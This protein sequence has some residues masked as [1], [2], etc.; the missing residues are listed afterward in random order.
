[1]SLFDRMW[2][3]PKVMWLHRKAVASGNYWNMSNSATTMDGPNAI[4][5]IRTNVIDETHI[6]PGITTVNNTLEQDGLRRSDTTNITAFNPYDRTRIFEFNGKAEILSHYAKYYVLKCKVRFDVVYTN[7]SSEN[8]GV[9]EPHYWVWRDMNQNALEQFDASSPTYIGSAMDEY[10]FPML[11]EW[12][13]AKIGMMR[14]NDRLVRKTFTKTINP[15]ACRPDVERD[16]LVGSIS[17]AGVISV[18]QTST[19]FSW[20][21]FCPMIA[22]PQNAIK[23]RIE[24]VQISHLVVF[25]DRR[26]EQ[27]SEGVGNTD[28]VNT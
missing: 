7:T 21:L 22:T 27:T 13:H 20:G 28:V 3:D 12:H 17:E 4:F 11:D 26:H 8:S 2:P 23:C 6:D 10:F 16:Q 24:N 9:T 14:T 18:P 5:A 19:W 15:L 25:F 1:M